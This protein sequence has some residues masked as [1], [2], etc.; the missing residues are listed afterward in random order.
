MFEYIHHIAYVVSD[1]PAEDL[2]IM[3]FAMM[4]GLQVQW[5]YEPE[6][7]DMARPFEQFLGFLIW[8]PKQTIYLALK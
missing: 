7:I 3:L 1:M 6:Q 4:D 8:S 5:L 2:V